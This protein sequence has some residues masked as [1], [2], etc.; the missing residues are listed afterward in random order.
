MITMMRMMM[1]KKSVWTSLPFNTKRSH[2]QLLPLSS[3]E[4]M[5]DQLLPL[6]L[7]GMMISSNSREPR[8]TK[9]LKWPRNTPGQSLAPWT[10]MERRH[11]VVKRADKKRGSH[12]EDLGSTIIAL[13]ERKDLLARKLIQIQTTNCTMRGTKDSSSLF[14]RKKRLESL[15]MN[16]SYSSL[17]N[18]AILR[19]AQLWGLSALENSTS[20]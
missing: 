6:I 9:P 19:K 5:S 3:A 17:S 8:S 1:T 15:A 11:M 7:T 14:W 10:S 20:T 18:Q 13:P 2:L 4:I 12:L 16:S